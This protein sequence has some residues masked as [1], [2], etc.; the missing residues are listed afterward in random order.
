MI[1]KSLISVAEA[2]RDHEG[3][4]PPNFTASP[5]FAGS[6]S[7][8]QNNPG[9]LRSSPFQIGQ[10]GGFAVFYTEELGRF[11]LLWDLYQKCTGN[12]VSGLT[13]A[14]TLADLIKVFAPPVENDTGA[15]I[16]SVEAKTGIARTTKLA[17]L[18]TK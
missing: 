4:L 11:G 2:I 17:E 16:A 10:N 13:G 9:N 3:W 14:S 15:Y 1:G 7:W 8:R 6:I 18:L 5:A 12:T